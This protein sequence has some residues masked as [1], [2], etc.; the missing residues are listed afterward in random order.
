LASAYLQRS[1]ASVQVKLGPG[2]HT[3]TATYEGNGFFQRS[4][5]TLPEAVLYV[6]TTTTLSAAPNPSAPGQL[7]T[8][9][10]SVSSEFSGTGQPTGTLTFLDGTTTLATYT[11]GVTSNVF[12]F[13]T[14]SLAVG[15][16]PITAAFTS[17]DPAFVGSTSATVTQTLDTPVVTAV[18]NLYL[19]LL[20]R[21]ADPV[22][23][24]VGGGLLD[25][26]VSRMIV[27]LAIE[28]SPEYRIH[29]VDTLYRRYLHH[30]ADSAGLTAGAIFLSTGGTPEQLAA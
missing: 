2:P 26:G 18:K 4:S 3:I 15:D 7:V 28:S 17:N 30:G 14:A 24:V 16:H 1:A 21:P 22:A 5:A 11:V 13:G 19:G 29:E 20:G 9:T 27:A 6:P 12:Q 23:L 8:F 25:R 10:A